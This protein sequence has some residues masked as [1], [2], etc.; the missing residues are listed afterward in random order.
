MEKRIAVLGGTGMA[1][2]I[3]VAYFDEQGFDVSYTSRTSPISPKSHPIDAMDTDSLVK[4]LDDL[5][6]DVLINC[7]GVLQKESEARPDRAIFI[8]GYLPKFLANRY[9]KSS[10]KIIHLSTDCVFSGTRGGYLEAENPNGETTYDR[11]KALGEIT[12]DKD[13][14]FRMSII[15]PDTNVNGTGLFNW[16]MSQS[17]EIRGYTKALWNGITSIELMRAIQKAL[18]QNLTGLYHLVA[19]N[20]IDKYN[21]LKLFKDIFNKNDIEIL[22]FD[23]FSVDKSLINTRIDFDF[24]VCSY[25]EQI[26]DMKIWIDE[27]ADMYPHYKNIKIER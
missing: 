21:L 5:N 4:W 22:P 24:D 19:P 14:T 18:Q 11:T 27:H 13:L 8:N 3:A 9:A 16:F 10:M 7:M 1:G 6:P 17:G 25:V 15:G 12:N 23:D 2:H 26:N 20:P